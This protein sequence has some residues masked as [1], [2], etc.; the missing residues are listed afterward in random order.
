MAPPKKYSDFVEG[1]PVTRMAKKLASSADDKRQYIPLTCPHCASVFI[2]IP[3]DRLA[4]NKASACRDHLAKCTSDIAKNDERRPMGTSTAAAVREQTVVMQT[5]HAESMAV[6]TEQLASQRRSEEHLRAMREAQRIA[7]CGML[8]L[9]DHS[10]DDED[11]SKVAV[12]TKRKIDALQAAARMEAFGCVA[13]AGRF[14]PPRD[15]EPPVAVGKR[16]V[17]CVTTA[18]VDAGKVPGLQSQLS[19]VNTEFGLAKGAP[20]ADRMNAI[21]E[22]K[23]DVSKVQ[24]KAKG[25]FDNVSYAAGREHV[26][27]QDQVDHVEALSKAATV[28]QMGASAGSRATNVAHM[29]RIDTILNLSG[30]PTQKTREEAI[31]GLKRAASLPRPPIQASKLTPGT[32]VY[33]IVRKNVNDARMLLHPDKS[34]PDL[35]KLERNE[36]G[37]KE[38]LKNRIGHATAALNKLKDIW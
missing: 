31:S 19:A 9:S 36:V 3:D 16:V 23:S 4:S 6:Q 17:E 12:R 38:L 15:D 20:P 33:D 25:H 34:N 30:R 28:A 1:D 7:I 8:G 26:S 37:A 21:R 24:D 11:G 32:V 22:L 14:S 18:V 2:E 5:Q 29:K 10:S 35:D 27:A 13:K